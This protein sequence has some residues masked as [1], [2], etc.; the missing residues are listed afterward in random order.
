MKEVTIN[1]GADSTF[2]RKFALK[3]SNISRDIERGRER[4][5][6]TDFLET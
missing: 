3:Y 2:G 4:F 5:G 6:W 1:V